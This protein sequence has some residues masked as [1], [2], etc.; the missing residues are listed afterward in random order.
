[1]LDFNELSLI[2]VGNNASFANR[3]LTASGRLRAGEASPMIIVRR[4]P[5][6]TRNGCSICRRLQLACAVRAH[7]AS[8]N[9]LKSSTVLSLPS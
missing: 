8:D 3:L 5:L 4:T 9:S 6:V 1:M 2:R 7:L